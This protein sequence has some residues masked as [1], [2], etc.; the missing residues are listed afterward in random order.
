VIHQHQSVPDAGRY[1]VSAI[2][3]SRNAAAKTQSTLQRL[4]DSAAN[5]NARL[6]IIVVDDASRHSELESLR[7]IADDGAQLIEAGANLGRGAAINLGASTAR[8]EYLLILDCDCVPSTHEYLR[9]HL[10]AAT[11]G[12]AI[13]VGPIIG[14]G[15]D[16]WS[17]YQDLA[18]QRRTRQFERGLS[19]A[20]TSANI[21][22]AAQ[23]FRRIGGFDAEYNRYGFE[24]RD[25]FLRASKMGAHIVYTPAAAV[26]HNDSDIDMRSTSLKMIETGRHTAF[27]FHST[28]P[29]AY[30]A[31]GY[32]RIDISRWRLLSRMIALIGVCIPACASLV[33]FAIAHRLLPFRF[34]VLLVNATTA[35]WFM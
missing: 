3:P 15:H 23:Q 8:G 31:L 25:F 30:S 32:A 19:C 18:T 28:H 22:I 6:E 27:H 9:H 2:I 5:L 13:S 11:A 21:L 29:E 10:D 4:R 12:A 1:C 20:F 17:R 24:D 35:I 16:F 34:G 26:V 14:R 7:R 33:D